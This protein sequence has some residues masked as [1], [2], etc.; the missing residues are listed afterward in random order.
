MRPRRSAVVYL[1][2][3][4]PVA[5]ATKTRLCPPLGPAQAARLAEAFLVDSLAL[6]QRTGCEVRL[7]CRTHHERR[8]LADL[9]GGAVQICVQP[10]RGLGDA[11]E[12]AFDQGLADG[13][14]SVAVIGADSPTLPSLVVRDAFRV[15]ERGADVALGPSD[16]GGYYLLAARALHRGL[17]RDMPWSTSRVG[18]LTLVRC[19]TAGLS[20]HVLPAWYDVDDSAALARLQAELRESARDIAPRTRAVLGLHRPGISQRVGTLVSYG[21]RT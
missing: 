8:V 11:L 9:V 7:M 13:F 3:K 2:A 14:G 1:I 19:Q 10:G 18:A 12:S 21:A 16:D 6:V 20:T 15:L 5:G 4:A 17:F